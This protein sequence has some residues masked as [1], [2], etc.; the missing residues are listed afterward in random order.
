MRLRGALLAAVLTA[1]AAP[2]VAAAQP[3]AAA[4]TW[5]SDG[6]EHISGAAD[7]SD[8][9][10]QVT[11]QSYADLTGAPTPT[12]PPPSPAPSPTPTPTPTEAPPPPTQ[13]PSPTETAVPRAA[14]S[15]AREEGRQSHVYVRDRG[16]AATTLLSEPGAGHATA[17]SISGSG[18]LVSWVQR[19][20]TET[21]ILVADRDPDADGVLDEPGQRTVR[22]VTGTESDLRYQRVSGCFPL[23]RA[24]SNNGPCGPQLSADGSTLAFP[25]WL[26]PSSP[27]LIPQI[28]FLDDL[29]LAELVDFER[30]AGDVIDFRRSARAGY[31]ERAEVGLLVEGDRAVQL[32]GVTIEGPGDAFRIDESSCTGTV[33]PGQR[34]VLDLVF[35]PDSNSCPADGEWH[36]HRAQ[37]VTDATT[38]AGRAAY[39][40]VADCW[41]GYQA[42]DSFAAPRQAPAEPCPAPDLSGLRPRLI[43]DASGRGF[44]YQVADAGPVQLGRTDLVALEVGPFEGSRVTFSPPPDCSAQLVT[45]PPEQQL[46]GADRPEPC[47]AGRDTLLSSCTAYV[48]LRPTGIR[49]EVASLDLAGTVTR[50][51][52]EGLRSVVIARRDL[53]GTGDFAGPDAPPPAVVSVDD[54]GNRIHGIE[55]S[56]SGD[57]RRVAFTSRLSGTPQVYVH[58]T[59]ARGDRSYQPG[60]TELVSILPPAPPSPPPPPPPSPDVPAPPP[61][62][63]P[64]AGSPSL[65]A[66]GNRVAFRADDHVHLRDLAAATTVQ[67]SD[68]FTLGHALSG[69][70]TTVA[71]ATPPG[72]VDPGG[73]RVRFLPDLDGGGVTETPAA[74]AADAFLPAIDAHGRHIAFDTYAPLAG[75]DENGTAD[76]YLAE[77]LPEVT[78]D[79]ATVDFGPLPVDTISG[80]REVTV[81]NAGPGPLVIT[82]T[83]LTGPFTAGDDNC[84]PALHRGRSCV[85]SMTFAPTEQ[86]PSTGTLTVSDLDADYTASL[87]GTGMVG[88]TGGP[89]PVDPD[90]DGLAAELVL[91]PPIAA[92][93]DAVLA[94]GTEFPSNADVVLTWRPGLGRTTVTSDPAG[95]FT[96]SVLVFP[97][98]RLGERVLV[99]TAGDVRVE[100]PPFLV[101]APAGQP[102][103]FHNRG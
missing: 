49:T 28:R 26:G 101:V 40:I 29:E 44:G 10:S 42:F 69:D 27:A 65:S 97:E 34:C 100:S 36:V 73:L 54:G 70:G 82:G 61:P 57:G 23:G 17:P 13:S 53:S 31:D 50:F 72:D 22:R 91:D 19:S 2:G 52:A 6:G 8:D 92:L 90:G 66:G 67:V 12:T 94:R 4:P 98:D 32:R 71:F 39:P 35:E 56:I 96:V 47:V 15:Q 16:R 3:P 45:P 95:A 24:G 38:P 63:P 51:V 88:G 20:G 21:D 1:A 48:L 9:G 7:L 102:P 79:P 43:S 37:L 81:S 77:R 76:V 103:G 59:D 86:G 62:P 55:P 58:D 5:I 33:E 89:T 93:G 99:G 87:T 85:I 41:G 30:P 68:R 75:A 74:D 64:A 25:G 18:R 80:P 78:L 46:P 60:S 83:P 11:F 84:G 14:S